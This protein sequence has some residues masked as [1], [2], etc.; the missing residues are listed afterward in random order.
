VTNHTNLNEDNLNLDLSSASFGVI[1]AGL[2]G[3]SG[4]IAARFDF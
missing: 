2:G 3:R 1:T 4:Q